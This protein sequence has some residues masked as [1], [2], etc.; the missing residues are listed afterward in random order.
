MAKKT[1]FISSP[2]AEKRYT[3][4]AIMRDKRFAHIQKDF[5][6]IILTKPFYTIQEALKAVSDFFAKE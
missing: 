1:D 3:P 4:K 5:L 2:E 6:G